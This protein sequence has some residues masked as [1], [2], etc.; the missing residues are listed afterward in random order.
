MHAS[1]DS[2]PKCLACRQVKGHRKLCVHV[3][4]HMYV[5][6]CGLLSTSLTS[7]RTWFF[8]LVP[9]A[10]RFK[11]WWVLPTKACSHSLYNEEEVNLLDLPSLFGNSWDTPSPCERLSQD[12]QLFLARPSG[13]SGKFSGGAKQCLEGL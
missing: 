12:T 7:R 8:A 1:E 3:L 6:N 4:V 9:W 11:Q 2:Y 10:W 13:S 5:D